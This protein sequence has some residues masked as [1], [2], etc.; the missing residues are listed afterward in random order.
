VRAEYGA[1]W[2]PSE[3]VAAQSTNLGYVE[4]NLSL[5][6]PLWQCATEEWSAGALVRNELFQT[7]AILPDSMQAFPEELWNIRLSTTFRHLFDNGWIGGGTVSVG[8]AS[9]KPFDSIKEMTAGVNAF[10]RVPQGE[11]N[12]WLFSLAYSSNSQLPI[13]IPGVAYVWVPNDR[14]RA[15]IGLPFL[16]SYRPL[17]DVTLDFSYMLLTNIH[18]R[19]TYCIRPFL[20]VYAGYDWQNEG[21]LLADRANENDIFFYYDQRLTTGVQYLF[22]RHASIDLSGGYV[23]DRFYFQGR[24][25]SDSHQDRIDVGNGPFISLQSQIRW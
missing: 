25:L 8:S 14:F 12:A 23:F 16:V 11:H 5:S 4:Q 21:Y 17:D 18:A 9:D 1:T 19:A 24:S 20:R 7:H 10:L 22:N 13:P 6:F 3:P 2:F 15:N